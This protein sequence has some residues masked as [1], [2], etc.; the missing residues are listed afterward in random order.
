MKSD[1]I[2]AIK[3]GNEVVGPYGR[4]FDDLLVKKHLRKCK[5][6]FK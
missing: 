6:F 1:K 3:E 5:L 4:F 2:S